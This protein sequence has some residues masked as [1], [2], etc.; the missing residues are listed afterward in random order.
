MQKH[1]DQRTLSAWEKNSAI[2]LSFQG[3]FPQIEFTTETIAPLL[4]YA[5][6]EYK[7]NYNIKRETNKK[8]ISIPT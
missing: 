1:R 8:K 6:T 2:S 3:L 7:P 4:I 5:L